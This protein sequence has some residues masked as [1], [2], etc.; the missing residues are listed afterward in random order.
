HTRFSRDWSSD[1]CSSD[2]SHDRLDDLRLRGPHQRRQPAERHCGRAMGNRRRQPVRHD[3]RPHR[4]ER[5]QRHR[6]AAP[7]GRAADLLDR[8]LDDAGRR[9]RTDR[10]RAGGH[11]P[12]R[13]V[14]GRDRLDAAVGVR[15]ARG[16]SRPAVV[17]RMSRETRHM[18]TRTGIP[19]RWIIAAAVAAALGAGHSTAAAQDTAAAEASQG[20]DEIVVAGRYRNATRQLIDERLN[21]AAVTDMLGADTIGRLGDSSVAAALRRIPGLSLVSDKYV[22]IRGLGERY[23]ASTLNGAHIPSPDLTRNVIPLDVFP[24][25]V[26]ESLRVQKAWS[27]DL[28]ANFA[29]GSVDIRTRGI[30]DDLALSFEIGSGFNTESSGTMLSYPG[31]SRDDLGTDNGERALPA[32]LFERIAE[33]QAQTDVQGILMHLRRQ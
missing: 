18:P 10:E 13:A 30:P 28:P 22:Y 14:A 21:D 5:G 16:Q 27:A 9:R 24:T 29:G 11:V 3:Q 19:R 20:V 8:V 17:V 31:G 1:V 33:F 2:L 15:P 12:R 25:S 26:V 23:S 6:P 7:R 32:S 4:P